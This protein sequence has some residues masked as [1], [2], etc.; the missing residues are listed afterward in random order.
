[1]VGD[2]SNAMNSLDQ[3]V[4]FDSNAIV[5]GNVGFTFNSSTGNLAV[6]GAI[7]AVGNVTGGNLT[8]AGNVTSGNISASGSLSVVGNIQT[9]S[10]VVWANSSNTAK[11][12]QF[13]NSATSSIDTVFV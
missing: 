6:P 8:T 9:S 7:T 1:M 3:Q 10:N 12:Y 13:Y 11:A 2:V 5:T 4:L